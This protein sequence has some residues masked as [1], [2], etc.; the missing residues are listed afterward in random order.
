MRS[1]MVHSI[2]QGAA[3]GL[4]ITCIAG[5]GNAQG[6]AK[7]AAKPDATAKKPAQK[8]APFKID[9]GKRPKPEDCK[10]AKW[11]PKFVDSPNLAIRASKIVTVA[12]PAISDGRILVSR[13]RITA[14]GK[15]SD[16]EVP[17]GYSEVDC[18]E[19]WLMPGMVDLHCH[20]AGDGFDLNDMVH[21][22]N[23]EFRTV[24]LV[25]L[26]HDQIKWAMHG[27]VTT[28]LYIP[29]SGT[30]MGGFGTITKVAGRSV[31]EALV[32]F[33]G[34]LKIAQ[35]G[36]PERGAGDMGTG[37]IGMNWGIRATLTRG[38]NYYQAW[39]DY[40]SGKSKTKPKFDPALEYLRG[41]FRHEYPVSVHTQAYQ[42]CLETLRELHD[43]F[44]LWT[45]VDHG[46]FD[47]YRMSGEARKRGVPVC[48]GPRQFLL[49]RDT[50]R[51]I[52]LAA[53]WALG[54]KHGWPEPVLGLGRD[55]IGINT[56]SPVIPQ[57]ELTVQAA[58]AVRLG[59]PWE[60]GIRGVTI[61][62]ARF[63]GIDHKVGSLEKGKDADIVL[64]TGDPLDPRSHVRKVWV[65]GSKYFDCD[66]GG[67]DH[68][69]RRI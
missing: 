32:R 61:N 41:L 57:E 30:N 33:P 65:N 25:G 46:T 35:A 66:P 36:N 13:G 48:N 45:F 42:V 22:T 20:V 40:D 49:D 10:V 12:G 69:K 51:M 38:K 63:A 58:M 16:I 9:Y 37:R 53:G 68:G 44:G 3:L 43:E 64:W 6:D 23:P 47:A 31:E 59:L 5:L 60:W 27:G 18:G 17:E 67:K 50:G 62:P 11:G 39:E 7:A 8:P 21:P 56:D 1:S 24:D 55:G 4:A 34:S 54:G 15:A 52:G 29:G 28:V 19:G 26:H 2:V 14:I